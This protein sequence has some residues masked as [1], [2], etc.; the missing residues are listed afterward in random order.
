MLGSERKAVGVTHG[1]AAVIIVEIDVDVLARVPQVSE[2]TGPIREGRPAVA[3]SRIRSALVQP[4]ISPIR[5]APERGLPLWGVTEAERRSVLPQDVRNFVGVPR[6]VTR[7][8]RHSDVRREG[9]EG[10]RQAGGV[11]AEV[12][13]KLQQDRTHLVVPARSSDPRSR[14]TGSVG[15]L[16]RST[17]VR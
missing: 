12:R 7:L 3:G 5:S 8:E 17:W 15:L 1:T 13:R 4:Q 10:G 16:S 9:L 11:G 2:T 14:R 6:F